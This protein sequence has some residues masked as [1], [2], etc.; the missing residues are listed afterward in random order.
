MDFLRSLRLVE[1][2]FC[3]GF[4]LHSSGKN[5][6]QTESLDSSSTF[7]DDPQHVDEFHRS[8]AEAMGCRADLLFEVTQVHGNAVELVT[9]QDNVGRFRQ[10]EAD[11][12]VVVE[13]NLAVGIRTADCLPLL[14]ADPLSGAVAAVHV[15]WRSAVAG[16][17]KASVL[18]LLS[19]VKTRVDKIEAAIFPHIRPCCF[20]I[21]KDVAELLHSVSY[22]KRNVHRRDGKL[23][24]NLS[25]TVRAQLIECG[26][27]SHRIED[28]EGCTCCHPER[29]HSY[30][31]DGELSGRHMAIIVARG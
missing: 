9:K 28:I 26:V 14:L 16:V 27:A 3:H 2:G 19:Q 4:S 1:L 31:R 7:K 24:G 30:R 13:S 12:L 11:A 8:F 5:N 18:M 21:G 20:E 25:S 15:G 23:Y 10:K 17:V 6:S 29:F 22:G